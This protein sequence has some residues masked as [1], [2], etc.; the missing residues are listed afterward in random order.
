[1]YINKTRNIIDL[2]SFNE[3]AI[4]HNSKIIYVVKFEDDDLRFT[5][6]EALTAG[7]DAALDSFVAT[8]DD[9]ISIN[10]QPI[11]Y[12]LAKEEAK[13]KHFHN[14]DYIKELISGESLIPERESGTVKGEVQEVI[15]YKDI[16]ATNTPETPV[17]KVS[18]TYYRD[19]SGFAMYRITVRQWYN[20]DGTLNPET[21]TSIKYYYINKQDMI[22]EGIKRRDL[23]VNTIQIPV[24]TLMAEVLMPL[25]VTQISVV[26]KGRQFLDDYETVFNNFIKNSSTIT[27]PAHTDYGRKT[28]IVSL[29]NETRS[30]FVEWLDLAPNS[31]GGAT[32]IRQYLI[33]QFDI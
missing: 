12:S 16:S 3:A 25:G 24:M 2:N 27:D 4:A 22:K 26:F 18:I 6:T 14:I 31:L 19:A 33:N 32:T 20:E 23:L 30:Q 10:S 13:H 5:I 29:E 21:K 1:M 9:N 8:Y 11:I 7:E 28:V 15:W 17:I